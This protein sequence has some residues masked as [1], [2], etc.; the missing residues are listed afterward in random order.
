MVDFGQNET[1]ETITLNLIKNILDRL[2][3]NE[4][5]KAFNYLRLTQCSIYSTF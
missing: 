1:S 3:N 4:K 2:S 5:E